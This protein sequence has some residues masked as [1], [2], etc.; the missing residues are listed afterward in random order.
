MQAIGPSGHP[1]YE[2]VLTP[3]LGQSRLNGEVSEIA[4]WQQSEDR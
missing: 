2:P 4:H 1:Q 3:F